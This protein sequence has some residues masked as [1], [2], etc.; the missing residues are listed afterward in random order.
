[1][2]KAKS[3]PVSPYLS[4]EPVIGEQG[5][6]RTKIYSIYNR[7]MG[8]FW[9]NNLFNSL[10]VQC[11][12]HMKTATCAITKLYTEFPRHTHDTQNIHVTIILNLCQKKSRH[13]LVV[14]VHHGEKD[15]SSYNIWCVFLNF[16][17]DASLN[18]IPIISPRAYVRVVLPLYRPMGLSKEGLK[19]GDPR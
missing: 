16:S 10:D 4:L 2:L 11:M 15:P 18:V 13:D 8:L 6:C 9:G 7:P 3:Y 14:H 1:M 19:Y 5:L 12:M 17:L